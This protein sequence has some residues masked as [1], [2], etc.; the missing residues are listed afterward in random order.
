MK[1]AFLICAM[2]G[3]R[4]PSLSVLP[5]ALHA[6]MLQRIAIKEIAATGRRVLLSTFIFAMSL[7][8]M[9]VAP[10]EAVLQRT[11]DYPMQEKE[12]ACLFIV[13]DISEIFRVSISFEWSYVNEDRSEAD[14]P[15]IKFR[16]K[17]GETLAAVLDNFCAA[18]EGRLR[19]GTIRGII[20]IWPAD[21]ALEMENLLDVRVS[22]KVDQLSTWHAWLELL[23]AVNKMVPADRYIV[24]GVQGFQDQYIPPW[25]LRDDRSISFDLVDVTAR[26]AACAIM[27]ASPVHAEFRYWTYYRPDLNSAS[28][29][30][31]MSLWPY[32]ENHKL[33]T[34]SAYTLEERMKAQ[35]WHDEMKAVR[36]SPTAFQLPPP[37][38]PTSWELHVQKHGRQ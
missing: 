25:I 16:I 4:V 3:A 26:E 24:P 18:T 11:A 32:D 31:Q 19:W 20:C 37:G 17:R 9:A 21:T 13:R 29:T 5:E 14:Y 12:E 15:K 22:L 1:T 10:E 28:P 30:A 36:E 33:I 27:A 38:S 6:D 35:I 7:T 34:E 2:L 23:R 8:A